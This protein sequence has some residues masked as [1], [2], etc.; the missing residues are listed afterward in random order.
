MTIVIPYLLSF[1]TGVLLLRRILGPASPCGLSLKTVLGFL[2]GLGVST[3][4][5]YYSVCALGEYRAGAALGLNIAAL[6]LLLFLNRDML[7]KPSGP[8]L[9]KERLKNDVTLYAGT[10]A[11][12]SI[13]A[14]GLVYLAATW[15][16]YGRWDAWALYN[17]KTKFILF[18][19]KNWTQLFTGLHWHTQPDYPLFLPFLNAWVCA[20]GRADFHAAAFANAI[21]FALL[22]AALVYA[23]LKQGINRWAALLA[24]AVLILNPQ[25]LSLSTSQY[26]DILLS[27]YLLAALVL[28]TFAF[29]WASPRVFFAAGLFTGFLPFIKN[30]GLVMA[31]LLTA[32]TTVYIC[33]RK[34][35]SVGENGR[36]VALFLIGVAF[37]AAAGISFK[38]FFAPPN[39]DMMGQMH[40]SE[41]HF[42]NWEGL[43]II[44]TSFGKEFSGAKWSFV[45]PFLGLAALGGV[46]Q[47]FKNGHGPMTVFFGLYSAVIVGIYLI[48]RNFDLSWRISVTL[49]RI[50]FYLLAPLLFFCFSTMLTGGAPPILLPNRKI[51]TRPVPGFQRLLPA[52]IIFL[53]L[54]AAY[55][56]TLTS[57]YLYHDDV[58]LFLKS[59]LQM[60]P[61]SARTNFILYGRFFGALVYT[62]SSW[63]IHFVNDLQFVRFLTVVE[64]TVCGVLLYPFLRRLLPNTL[65]A[66]VFSATLL[67][68]PGFQILVS[69]AGMS[70]DVVGAICA[71]FAAQQASRIPADG[72]VFRRL[73]TPAFFLSVLFFFLGLSTHQSLA[74]FYWT[75]GVVILASSY[76]EDFRTIKNKTVNI[77]GAGFVSLGLYAVALKILKKFG[78]QYVTGIHNPFEVRTDV[79][80]QIRWFFEEPLTNALNFWNI[81]PSDVIASFGKIVI[82]SGIAVFLITLF[83]DAARTN[84]LKKSLFL[85][86][87]VLSFLVLSFLPNLVM[88]T[89]IPY[90]RCIGPLSAI[91][92][93]VLLWAIGEWVRLR[94]ADKQAPVMTGVCLFLG[95]LAALLTS[96]NLLLYRVIPART[97]TEFVLEKFREPDLG[98]Y[99]RVHFFHPDVKDLTVRFDEFGMI[100][101]A[102]EHD[103]LGLTACGL[104]ERN[105][106]TKD[107]SFVLVDHELETNEFYFIDKTPQKNLDIYS[108]Q[109]SGSVFVPNMPPD[110]RVLVIDVTPFF[111]KGGSLNYLM[112][113]NSGEEKQSVRP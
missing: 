86:A 83:S 85:S 43:R 112:K 51:E 38:L 75:M 22:C 100:T 32:A 81:F 47:W 35:L 99:K 23:G 55:A 79:F 66:A 15:V 98:R 94:P 92:L 105:R 63:L 11:C 91:L 101:E 1:A 93:V 107:F 9:S 62:L 14:T 44:L 10:L 96:R 25:Y 113:K 27:T 58:N 4:L 88:L 109:I 95:L 68:L 53:V 41:M 108:L 28:A 89:R 6:A 73:R 77:S 8:I 34:K 102:Y 97:L 24:V 87:V 42:L 2:L 56:P 82:L 17:M 7:R 30:E 48:T 54:V 106:G 16:P 59:P 12:V 74:M 13:V 36:C 45:W 61:V 60:L 110:P 21:V 19:G 3:H 70:F 71:G 67:T 37:T 57:H 49:E 33:C 40:F 64:L 50:C 104:I 90:Y 26:A 29:R 39:R 65:S 78:M 76:D 31:G 69:Q 72:P 46:R 5:T 18:A 103:L 80:S 111:R 52:G 20:S 84:R